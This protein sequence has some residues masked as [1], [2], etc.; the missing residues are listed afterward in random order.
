MLSTMQISRW[1]G[2]L[3]MLSGVIALAAC[4]PTQQADPS[5]FSSWLP[6]MKPSKPRAA[7]AQP[8]RPAAR[9]ASP[10]AQRTPS[11]RPASPTAAAPAGNPANL[12]AQLAQADQH[13]RNGAFAQAEQAYKLAVTTDPRQPIAHYRL[14]NIAFR[15]GSLPEAAQHFQRA[16]ELS[17]R[18][19]KAHYNL[20]VVYLTLVEK[21]FKHY[22]ATM[23]ADKETPS[24]QRLLEDIDAFASQR[25]QGGSEG[26]N[27]R[28]QQK[29]SLDALAEA[30]Q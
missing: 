8:A 27:R 3:V 24:I 18:N 7:A 22:N 6:G 20:G 5:S 2:R 14:G 1:L 30:L 23:P 9:P 10:I 16:I 11:A 21:H 28:K 12:Q 17:P 25:G 4:A 15:K 13:Y 26:G 29:D 19:A